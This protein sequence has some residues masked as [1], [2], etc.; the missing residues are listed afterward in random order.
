MTPGE[1]WCWGALTDPS[2]IVFPNDTFYAVYTAAGTD[3]GDTRTL[4]RP[5]AAR[6]FDG[7]GWTMSE[8]PVMTN[9]E[10][11]TWDSAAVET[12]A[13]LLDGDSII[14]VYAGDWAHGS[15]D[16]ALG[17]A[18]STDGGSTFHRLAEGPILERDTTRPEE[19]RSIESPTLLRI[20]DS[21][22]MWYN[23]V[24]EDWHITVCRASSQDGIHWH[25]YSG[26]P[27]LDIGSPGDFDEIGI[28]SPSVRFIGDSLGMLYQGLALGD[29][30][31]RWEETYLGWATSS[32]GGITWA[33]SPDNP[34]LGPEAPGSW[35]ETGPKTPSFCI[36]NNTITVIFWNG[37]GFSSAGGLGIA[38][39]TL[40]RVDEDI[41]SPDDLMLSIMPN[42][43]NSSCVI[44]VET[45][46][47][48]SLPPEI[49]IYDLRGNL[50]ATPFGAC[51]PLSPLSRGTNERSAGG[52]SRGFVWQ[53]DEKIPS[54]IYLV[55]A[56]IL[57]QTKS[58]VCTKRIVY[59]R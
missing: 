33:R 19:Y 46:N 13:I 21:L 11:G 12:P 57:Q 6:S 10:P 32:D 37:G 22:I 24:S 59:V 9:G 20:G 15:G 43:F 2:I 54:G 18:V 5:G 14:M 42:P 56:T 38:T 7:F 31:Y 58:V 16:I 1:L 50:I 25:R 39:H 4:T 27:V 51:A 49:A 48:A 40:S 3:S 30:G 26:N 45:Q 29:S 41:L 55:R 34:I 47:L 23:G 36:S 28:Y 8:G 35:N 52:A 44:F 53:P 17:I